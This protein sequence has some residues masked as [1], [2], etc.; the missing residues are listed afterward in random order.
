MSSDTFYPAQEDI[1][2]EG[3]GGGGLLGN[4]LSGVGREH[5]RKHN[6]TSFLKTQYRDSL[7]LFKNCLPLSETEKNPV[8]FHSTLIYAKRARPKTPFEYAHGTTGLFY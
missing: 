6:S 7:K 8:F 4:N 3:V 2:I 1:P 5:I